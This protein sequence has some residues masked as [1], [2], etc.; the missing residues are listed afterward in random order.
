N[1]PGACVLVVKDGEA[2]LEKGYGMADVEAGIPCATNTDFRLAS[3]TKQFTAMAVMLLAERKKLSLNESLTAVFPEFPKYGRDIT[4][5]HL[6]THTSG[7]VDYEDIIPAGTTI[8]VLDRDVLRLLMQQEKGYF[9]PG[10]KFKYS[11]SGYALLAQII[12]VR[13]GTPYA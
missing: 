9:P 1:V 10:S 6:L 13:S 3:V 2:V 8:P 4:V 11:N 12:E 5:R 7:L